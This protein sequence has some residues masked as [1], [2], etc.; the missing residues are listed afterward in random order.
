MRSVLSHATLAKYRKEELLI[1]TDSGNLLTSVAKLLNY[2]ISIVCITQGA[3]GCIIATKHGIERY[4]TF[5]VDIVDT[6]GAGDSFFGAFLA[7]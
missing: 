4:P 6:L 1:L 3:K 5:K 7:R 2:G